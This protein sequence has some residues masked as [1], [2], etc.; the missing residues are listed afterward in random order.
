MALFL[1]SSYFSFISSI[2]TANCVSCPLFPSLLIAFLAFPTLHQVLEYEYRIQA[3]RCKARCCFCSK[4]MLPRK[5]S[6]HLKYFCGPYA[7]RTAKQVLCWWALFL[8]P[9][10]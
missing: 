6:M 4:A 9:L 3:E 10:F 5:L 1:I 2:D 7:S 8:S